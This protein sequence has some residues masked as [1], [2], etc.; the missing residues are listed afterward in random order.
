[1]TT[2]RVEIKQDNKTTIFKKKEPDLYAEVEHQIAVFIRN[3]AGPILLI[4]L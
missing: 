3:E 1:M 2:K 4:S